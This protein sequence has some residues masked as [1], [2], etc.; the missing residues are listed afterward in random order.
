M[1]WEEHGFIVSNDTSSS[2]MTENVNRQDSTPLEPEN[3]REE[4]PVKH[5]REEVSYSKIKSEELTNDEK[6]YI[7]K[8]K[9]KGVPRDEESNKEDNT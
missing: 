2:S 5:N 6:S 1:N 9:R 4:Q 7:H 8:K 3:S